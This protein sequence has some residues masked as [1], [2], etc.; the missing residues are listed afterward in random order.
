MIHVKEV[1]D[2]YKPKYMWLWLVSAFKAGLINSAGFL[3]TG[4]FVSH[5]T[6]FGTQVGIAFGHDEYFF[7]AE[8][9]VIPISFIAGGVITSAILDKDYQD[10]KTPPYYLVQGL[11]TVLII[12]IILLEESGLVSSL[13]PFDTDEKYNF[14]EFL[15]ISMLCL[16]CGLKNALV[17]WTT[18]GK[19]RISHLTG[20]G[21]D[22]GLHLIRT[23][24]PKQ[25]SPQFKEKRIVNWVRIFTLVSFSIGALVSAIL[26]PIM[27]Y[28]VFFIVM[29]LSV[30]MTIYSLKVAKEEELKK[31][32]LP[33]EQNA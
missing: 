11:I 9:L 26:F 15:I 20:L 33:F 32:T 14:V 31:Y 24:N 21:T 23:F 18:Q 27:G 29:F 6:G 28:K 4:K 17:T 12:A 2:I 8:L 3:A 13:V 10:G 1:S 7:G 25:P 5:I 16:V 30:V 19:I 22:I